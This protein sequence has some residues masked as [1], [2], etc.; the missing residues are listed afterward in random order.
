MAEA[1]AA[2]EKPGG[3]AFGPF[4]REILDISRLFV[5]FMAMGCYGQAI[6]CG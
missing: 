5:A 3:N 4:S 1:S 6:R 2:S